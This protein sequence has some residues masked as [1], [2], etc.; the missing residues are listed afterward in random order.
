MEFSAQ[1]K[2]LQ[3]KKQIIT[4][5]HINYQL[6]LTTLKSKPGSKNIQ[7]VKTDI[8]KKQIILIFRTPNINTRERSE[9]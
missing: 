1:K 4:N 9:P 7:I 2:K 6:H 8:N 5:L 3:T